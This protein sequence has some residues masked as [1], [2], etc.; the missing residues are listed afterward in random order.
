MDKWQEK[1]DE[2]ESA[3]DKLNDNLSNMDS[4]LD[5]IDRVYDNEID[6]IQAIIDGLKDAND[7]RD[8]TLALEKAKY[9]LEKAYSQR[10]KKVKHMPTA[11]V[12]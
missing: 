12:I 8:R 4:A 9:E 1:I 7:E 2:L 5:A 10:I 3:N 11:I 6:R